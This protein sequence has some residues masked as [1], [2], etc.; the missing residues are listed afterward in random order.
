MTHSQA[1]YILADSTSQYATDL[2]S[3]PSLPDI[4]CVFKM[5]A[6]V[7]GKKYDGKEN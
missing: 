4:H 7:R 3:V 6:K 1:V 5:A 2:T